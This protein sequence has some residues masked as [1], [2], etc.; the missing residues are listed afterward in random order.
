MNNTTIRINATGEIV[1]ASHFR[2]NIDGSLTVTHGAA[3]RL[4][5]YT[6]SEWVAL[7]RFSART[8]VWEWYGSEDDIGD[9]EHGRYKAKGGQEVI[10]W[11]TTAEYAAGDLETR[12]NNEFNRHGL[13]T[14][15]DY[16]EEFAPYY[17]PLVFQL[18]STVERIA[19]PEGKKESK[20]KIDL[21]KK[22]V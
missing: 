11:A 19:L 2:F 4:I 21:I 8:Q 14:R 1:F 7:H 12:F 5:P 10:I 9:L 22:A 20:K 6:A 16:V 13:S 15:Y 18:G 3:Y 17:D